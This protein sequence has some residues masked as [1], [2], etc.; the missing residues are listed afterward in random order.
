MAT[1]WDGIE[2]RRTDHNLATHAAQVANVA[3]EL[4][5]VSEDIQDIKTTTR[6]LAENMSKL[7]LIEDRQSSMLNQVNDHETRIRGLEIMMPAVTDNAQRGSSFS[8]KIQWGAIGVIGLL[9]GK[10][11]GV[12]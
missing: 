1:E 8:D 4:K 7:I 2:K 11:L 3:S 5:R 6:E 10:V 9:V 12:L